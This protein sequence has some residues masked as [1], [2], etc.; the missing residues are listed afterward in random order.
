M[1]RISIM[2]LGFTVMLI[3]H[4]AVFA[5]IDK[6]TILW[7]KFDEE[8]KGEIED[9]SQYGNNGIITGQIKF[10]RNGKIGGAGRF[11]PG[12]QIRIP[13]SDSLNV[14][15]NLTIEFWVQCDKV[16]AATYWRLIHKGWVQNGSCI[17]GMDNNWM[18]LGYTW[19]I[20]NTSGSAQMPIK[21]TL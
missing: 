1:Q 7:Y 4:H 5:Q 10:E 11:T 3:C 18:A 14:E 16:P 20:N 17:C 8:A 19:D 12:N 9:I 13:I 21:P 15:Q 2:L 6:T